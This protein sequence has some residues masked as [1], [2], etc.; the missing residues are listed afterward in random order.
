[1]GR[2]DSAAGACVKCDLGWWHHWGAVLEQAMGWSGVGREKGAKTVSKGTERST[3]YAN[4]VTL[5]KIA[6]G[7]ISLLAFGID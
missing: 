3:Y 7:L 5:L 6:A 4:I 2:P 1:M